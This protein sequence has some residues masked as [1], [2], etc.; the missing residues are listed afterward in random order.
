[1]ECNSTISFETKSKDKASLLEKVFNVYPDTSPYTWTNVE[2]MN[3][4]SNKYLNE[5]GL[6]LSAE[7]IHKHL[8]ELDTGITE[9]VVVGSKVS[10]A[11]FPVDFPE[12]FC[13]LLFPFLDRS[14]F[15]NIECESN[16]EYGS[17]TLT[18]K[19]NAIVKDEDMNEF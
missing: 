11:L 1:M 3:K 10:I 17:Q 13:E 8:V 7:D 19:N 14:G 2:E 9:T 6:S 4:I 15:E 12:K 18:F 16:S 5:L